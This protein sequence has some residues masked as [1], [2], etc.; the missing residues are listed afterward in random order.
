MDS[1]VPEQQLSELRA[2]DDER[3]VIGILLRGMREY[4]AEA[5]RIVRA[6]DF[7]LENAR[8][9]FAAME[10]LDDNGEPPLFTSVLH[11][12]FH[13]GVCWAGASA[14]LTTWA[15]EIPTP[16]HVKWHC[17][18]VARAAQRRRLLSASNKIATTAED[19]R[20]SADDAV[21]KAEEILAAVPRQSHG[22]AQLIEP[23]DMAVMA[24]R[25]NLD[26]SD[27]G[28]GHAIPLDLLDL[29]E[30]LAGGV[31]P[32]QLVIVG[33]RPGMGKSA[34]MRHFA[35]SLTRR[36]AVLF[37]SNEMTVSDINLRDLSVYS[38]VSLPIVVQGRYT[39]DELTRI[40]GAEARIAEVAIVNYV[41]HGMQA[42][43]LHARALELNARW[44]IAG[45]VV[46]YL[47]RMVGP[48]KDALERVGNNVRALKSLALELNV[49][50][51]VG[52][53][54]S[55]A[56]E[57]QSKLARPTLSDLRESGEIEQE[58]D[59]VLLLWRAS[60]YY[61]SEQEWRKDNRDSEPW[62][63]NVAEI[64]IAKQRQGIA[65]VTVKVAWL[66]SIADFRDLR[67]FA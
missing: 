34:L 59:I 4:V 11:Q 28:D 41:D 64:I 36:G 62:P 13:D 5:R 26:V 29:D 52:S 24:A 50:V 7:H 49:P 8:K 18:N 3:A 39:K 1:K 33:G 21:K 35:R 54:L 56:R 31:R 19:T 43:T 22:Q 60:A 2:D 9:A 10:T 66:G 14:D 16:I 17:L 45:I 12:L 23:T 37:A 40:T 47:Q 27:G 46:D 55:R 53:Q 25:R 48:G 20:F 15:A 42:A 65:G 32:G 6:G 61:G 67:I 57:Q 58:A 63:G 38:G 51:I 44:P 30:T